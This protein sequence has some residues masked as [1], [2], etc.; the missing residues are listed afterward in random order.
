[1]QENVLKCTHSAIQEEILGREWFLEL[2]YMDRFRW[3]VLHPSCALEKQSSDDLWADRRRQRFPDFR[4]I[5]G[6]RHD[7]S[8]NSIL[9]VCLPHVMGSNAILYSMNTNAM[10]TYYATGTMLGS[11]HSKL[12]FIC[13]FSD[14]LYWNTTYKKVHS[15]TKYLCNLQEIKKQM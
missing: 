4:R 9:R 12:F 8:I 11:F 3:S 5:M 14:T 2:N 15:I 10:F 13:A 1:M 6:M 7:D